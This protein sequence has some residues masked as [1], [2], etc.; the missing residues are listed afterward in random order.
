MISL[1]RKP[2]LSRTFLLINCFVIKAHSQPVFNFSPKTFKIFSVSLKYSKIFSPHGKLQ[3]TQSIVLQGPWVS[4]AD[5]FGE[6]RTNFFSCKYLL[7]LPVVR[8]G[9]ELVNDVRDCFVTG[10][11]SILLKPSDPSA[12]DSSIFSFLSILLSFSSSN[13]MSS[14]TVVLS[15]ISSEYDSHGEDAYDA[16]YK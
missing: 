16:S 5:N 9:D 1:S 8:I 2:E 7:V 13:I 4:C 11:F 6:S 12:S 14:E 10:D 15:T 3:N